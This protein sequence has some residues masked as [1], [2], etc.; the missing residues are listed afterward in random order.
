MILSKKMLTRPGIDSKN[1]KRHLNTK[2]FGKQFTLLYCI[3]LT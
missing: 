2:F 1:I 3:V